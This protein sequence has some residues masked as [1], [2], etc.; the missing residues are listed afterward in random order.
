MIGQHTSTSD[1]SSND[2]G[3]SD[4]I[5]FTLMFSIII[6]GAG[7]ISLS[8]GPQIAELSE[9]EEVR[10]AE[11]G[12][13]SVAGTIQP[14]VS[15]GDPERTVK[16]AFSNSKILVNETYLTVDGTRYQVNAIEQRFERPSQD[17]TIAYESGGV[18]RTNGV[19]AYEP[20]FRCTERNGD[21]T[22][23][24]T[25]V[26]LNL[27]NKSNFELS[28]GTGNYDVQYREFVGN[29]E[30]PVRSSDKSIEFVV[31]RNRTLSNRT[32]YTTS[33]TINV[34][35]SETSNPERWETYFNV[36]ADEDWNRVNSRE[37]ECVNADQ[38]I[39]RVVTLDIDPIEINE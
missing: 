35:F 4:A 38:S 26:K 3:V 14:M 5:G 18:F 12:M 21:K 19:S 31:Q 23:V 24:I 15:E 17:I 11:R 27:I 32:V 10:S 16:F 34:G 36:S 13:Q 29:E 9:Y 37:Y 1:E 30:V 7:A 39:V 22:A 2:R 25:V 33:Q 28:Q 20:G 6:L 8:G